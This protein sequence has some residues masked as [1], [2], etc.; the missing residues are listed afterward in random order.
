MK[1][2]SSVC[3]YCSTIYSDMG[4]SKNMGNP[5]W[6][7]Y[8]GKP[9]LKWM[10]WGYHYFRKPPYMV[11]I[12]DVF[13]KLHDVLCIRVVENQLLN[14]SSDTE[15]TLP[16]TGDWMIVVLVKDSPGILKEK[17]SFNFS[18]RRLTIWHVQD[19]LIKI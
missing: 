14:D 2:S 12:G 7:I 6:M 1:L 19:G 3:R 18:W 4:V 16:R 10:I 9:Y 5:K 17:H 13:S 8:N 11:E 15:V